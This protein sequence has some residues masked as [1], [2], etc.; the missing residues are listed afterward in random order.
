ME[1]EIKKDEEKKGEREYTGVVVLDTAS[2]R[3]ELRLQ[4]LPVGF[5]DWS[6]IWQR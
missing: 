4:I 3:S 6:N 1:N 2:P 5:L